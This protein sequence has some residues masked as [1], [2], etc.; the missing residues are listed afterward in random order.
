MANPDVITPALSETHYIRVMLWLIKG[1]DGDHKNKHFRILEIIHVSKRYANLTL[2][3][4]NPSLLILLANMTKKTQIKVILKQFGCSRHPKVDAL[5]VGLGVNSTESIMTM[6]KPVCLLW[7]L[8]CLACPNYEVARFVQTRLQPQ[9]EA[10]PVLD[11]V[12]P[13]LII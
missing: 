8:E 2:S 7:S 12:F 11:S 9:T 6:D 3:N 5:T 13:T 10:T 1:L 4:S